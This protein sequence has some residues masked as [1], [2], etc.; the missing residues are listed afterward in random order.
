MRDTKTARALSI[1]EA[2]ARMGVSKRTV[3]RL[4]DDPDSGFPRPRKIRRRTVIMEDDLEEWL[5]RQ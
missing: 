4:L 5:R 3:Y 1:L 2:A